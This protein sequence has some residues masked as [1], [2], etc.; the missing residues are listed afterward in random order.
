M[1]NCPSCMKASR[2]EWLAGLGGWAALSALARRGDAQIASIDVQVQGT[3]ESCIFINLEGA[4]SQLDPGD[5][6]IRRRPL[7]GHPL[8]RGTDD[9]WLDSAFWE[10]LRFGQGRGRLRGLAAG[11]R[12]G[13]VP[14]PAGT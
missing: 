8:E 12:R 13:R 3:A 9:F 4:P 5:R 11:R 1:K 14:R 7:A 6:C 10:L 2:R